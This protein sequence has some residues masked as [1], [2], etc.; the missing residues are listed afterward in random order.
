[1]WV[2][3]GRRPEPTTHSVP[4]YPPTSYH[5]PAS[6]G[7]LCVQNARAGK[8]IWPLNRKNRLTSTKFISRHARRGRRGQQRR[9]PKR[10]APGP[11]GTHTHCNVSRWSPCRWVAGL[12]GPEASSF[13]SS[14]YIPSDIVSPIGRLRLA[15]V[16]KRRGRKINYSG[17]SEKSTRRH[18]IHPA[19]PPTSH[20][21]TCGLTLELPYTYPRPPSRVALDRRRELPWTYPRPPTGV[22]LDFFQTYPIPRFS[23][24]HHA[25]HDHPTVT[26]LIPF[27]RS[28]QELS[29]DM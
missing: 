1:M 24:H 13:A 25:S 6:C 28:R 16:P 11:T 17:E 23:F 19:D 20:N 8:F 9:P 26:K 4:T 15:L 29:I 14:P 22:A 18:R 12:A 3:A 10:P 21:A 7:W 5:P 27:D 2:P